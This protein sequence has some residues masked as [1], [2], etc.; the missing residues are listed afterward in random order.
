MPVL[1]MILFGIMEYGWFFSQQITMVSAVRDSVRAGATTPQEWGPVEAAEL[2][3]AKSLAAAGCDGNVY[4]DISLSGG[5]P[6]QLISVSAAFAYEPLIGF[7]PSP[8]MISSALV[9]RMEDQPD[10]SVN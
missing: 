2:Q 7:V 3:L 5:A 10:T 8:E 1:I 4:V 6:D 9:M